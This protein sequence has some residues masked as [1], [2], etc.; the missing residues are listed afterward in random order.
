MRRLALSSLRSLCCCRRYAAYAQRTTASI[1]GTVRDATQGVLPGVTVTATNEDTGL[2]RSVVTNDAGVYSAADLP[3]GRYKVEAEL[4]SFK[5]ASRTNVVL[6]VADEFSIDFELVGR[7]RHGHRQ[8]RGVCDAGQGARR[9][10]LGRHH[11]RAGARASAERPQLPA[12]RHADAGRERAGLPQRQGQ[13]A[14]RR[15]GPVGQ[16]QRRHREP[17]DR[18]RREQQRR[19][20]EPDDPRVSVARGDL[21]SSRSCATT[22]VPSTAAPAA[23]RSTSSRRRAPTGSAGRRFYSGRSDALNAKNYF[24]KTGQPAEGRSLKRNDFGGSIGGP[25]VKDKLHFF[26]NAEWNIEDRG[27]A[28]T[29]FVP[30]AGRAQWR[31]QRAVDPRVL[32]RRCPSTRDGRGR[33]RAIGF[34]PTGSAP[35]ARR[36]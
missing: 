26:G 7:Q 14:A 10:R 16:R 33:S 18:R 35:P 8:R 9:R 1:R 6:R 28:R 3:I 24:L 30:T 11:R 13:G 17:V 4:A 5:K 12:A 34:P 27:T 31:L 2:V 20:V 36:S 15:I 32:A 25:I 19:R 21:R 22:T 23:R 29:A